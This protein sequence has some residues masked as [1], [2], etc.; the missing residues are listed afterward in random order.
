MDAAPTRNDPNDRRPALW[1]VNQYAG[2]PHHGMEFRHYELGRELSAAG[3]DIVVISGSYSHLLTKP[4]IVSG[5]Y[6]IENVDGL[7]YC[8]VRLP[9]YGRATGLGRLV[10]MVVFLAR[11]YR[12]PRHRLPRPD[13]IV[14]SSP[15]PFPVL[16]AQRWARQTGARLV[17][18]VRDIWPLTL[19]ELGGLSSRHPLVVLLG[20][21]ERRAYRAADAVV[22]V[23][24]AAR[25]HLETHGMSPTK[26]TVVPNGIGAEAL[27]EP[28]MDPPGD[29][30]RAASRA[31]FNVGFVGTLG[32]ANALETLVEAARLLREEDIGFVLVGHGPEERR[33]RELA[34]GLDRVAFPGSVEK[35]DVPATLRLF[36][37]CYVGYHRSALYRFGIAPNKVY[38]YLAAGR[39]VI[40]AAEASNDVVAEAGAGLT[41]QPDDPPALAEA[42]R[43]IRAMSAADRAVLGSSGRAFVEREHT[44]RSLAG[45][46]LPVLIGDRA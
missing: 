39:P 3:W 11:L 6:T 2:S 13:A 19:Q 42:I 22:S 5:T 24:P 38:D 12:L 8:W 34:A 29:V 1:I 35:A 46:Y 28:T 44:Y 41:V 7:T 18:E 40:L 32:I 16:P 9:S 37:C 20:W 21:F 25:S 43:S 4:P 17:F 10:N 30:R 26:L 45:R 31:G 33:L 23:L 15:S 27:R 14:V 36:D